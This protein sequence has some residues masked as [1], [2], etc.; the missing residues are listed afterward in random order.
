MQLFHFLWSCASASSSFAAFRSSLMQSFHLLLGLPLFLF[1]TSIAITLFPT[2]LFSRL[3]T[4][5][6]HLN[7]P[8]LIFTPSCPTFNLLLTSSFFTLSSLVIPHSNLSI[9]ISAT[10][11][12]SILCITAR[13]SVLY[14]IAGLTTTLCSLPFTLR[15][16]FQSH[17]TPDTFLQLFHPAAILFATSTLLTPSACTVDLRYLNSVTLGTFSPCIF[18]SPSLSSSLPPTYKCSFFLSADVHSSILQ[19]SPPSF[20]PFLHF[21]L[22]FSTDHY[23]RKHHRP[24]RFTSYVFRQAIHYH[25]K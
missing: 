19:S 15:D 4:W 21:F 25:G 17:S 9:L 16:T 8:S 7:L 14:I 3:T 11:N 1:P 23:I 24:R 2:Y 20:Q 6:K 22:S 13:V 18:S 12:F 5:P 10:S